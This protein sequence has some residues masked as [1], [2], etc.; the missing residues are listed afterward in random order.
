MHIHVNYLLFPIRI[1]SIYGPASG[2]KQEKKSTENLFTGKYLVYMK[3]GIPLPCTS[4]SRKK[5]LEKTQTNTKL[6][7]EEFC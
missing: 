5:N 2:W 4:K 3:V 7:A 1:F 6:N